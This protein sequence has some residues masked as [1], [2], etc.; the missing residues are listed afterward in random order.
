[1]GSVDVFSHLLDQFFSG[2]FIFILES[3]KEVLLNFLH[4][5]VTFGVKFF[6]ELSSSQEIFSMDGGIGG[7]EEGIN[8]S[9]CNFEVAFIFDS[10]FDSVESL[11]FFLFFFG[12]FSGFFHCFSGISGN[13]MNVFSGFFLIS[14]SSS[15][16]SL[17]LGLSDI[18]VDL[19]GLL[20]IGLFLNFLDEG[21]GF[22]NIIF[23]QGIFS[24][25]QSV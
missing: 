19:D 16:N 18:F 7:V 3:F 24:L 8:F 9:S 1:M 10:L 25:F 20:V 23:G 14:F 17:G 21:E 15:S 13:V 11:L 4:F 12:F 2:V 22:F 6:N 5:S